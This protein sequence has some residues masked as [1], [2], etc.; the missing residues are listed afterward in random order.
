MCTKDVFPELFFWLGWSL[1]CW[2]IKLINLL[3]YENVDAVS[4]LSNSLT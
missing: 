2:L 1:A 3:S 4:S